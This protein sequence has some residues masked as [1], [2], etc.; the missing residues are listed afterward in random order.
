M[1]ELE[2][3]QRAKMYMEKLAQGIDP[4]SDAEIPGDSVLNQVRLARCF[5]YVSDVL[6]KVIAN[7]GTFGGGEDRPPFSITAQELALVP[8]SQEPIRITRFTEQICGVVADQGRKKL[9]PTVI[10]NWLL[11]RG[12]LVKQMGPEGKGRRVPSNMGIDLGLSA[13]MQQ[14]RY[15]DYLA[16]FYNAN[17]QRFILDNLLDILAESSRGQ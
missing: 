13:R 2:K 12:F 15:G 6:G 1:T 5:F 4:I 7:G 11:E 3:L 8:I 16:V 9:N 17:A 14:G 10:T